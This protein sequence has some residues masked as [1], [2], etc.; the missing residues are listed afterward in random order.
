[1]F[2]L[3]QEFILYFPFLL[4]FVKGHKKVLILDFADILVTEMVFQIHLSVK[5]FLSSDSENLI[6]ETVVSSFES[7]FWPRIIKAMKDTY[8]VERFSEGILHKLAAENGTDVEAYWCIWLLYN[9]IVYNVPLWSA[10]HFMLI[11]HV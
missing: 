5:D 9:P 3:V 1:M 6:S 8:V 4:G 2:L 7:Q 10:N 11:R